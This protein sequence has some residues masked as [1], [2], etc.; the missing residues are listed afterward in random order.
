M[1]LPKEAKHVYDWAP[2]GQHERTESPERDSDNGDEEKGAADGNPPTRNGK[3]QGVTTS[4][5]PIEDCE[6]LLAN[7][8]PPSPI[9]TADHSP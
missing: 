9:P 4:V 2:D 7:A 1:L 8:W 3:P 6:V 5:A